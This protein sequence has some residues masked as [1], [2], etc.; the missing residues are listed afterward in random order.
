MAKETVKQDL[1]VIDENLRHKCKVGL[2]AFQNISGG[3]NY[4]NRLLELPEPKDILLIT[5]LFQS[6]II[7]YA[8]PFTNNKGAK[9]Y[10]FKNL[11]KVIGFD[12]ELHDHIIDIRQTLIAHDDFTIVEP[13]LI[14]S[15]IQIRPN[16]NE[17]YKILYSTQM[18]NHC[19][20]LPS[21]IEFIIK[22][23]E[24]FYKTAEIVYKQLENDV[25][26][27]QQFI[28]INKGVIKEREQLYSTESL[29]IKSNQT[30]NVDV[31]DPFQIGIGNSLAPNFEIA[32]NG[33]IYET[34]QYKRE[35]E[36]PEKIISIAGTEYF[37]DKIKDPSS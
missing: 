2:K 10:P 30:F 14:T 32:P 16:D 18:Q 7:R 1:S 23:Q 31:P 6:A 28:D 4:L 12:K 21:D 17:L 8:K 29:S 37:L 34:S 24:H 35:Y 3:L 19:L 9:E 26:A 20:M 13:A 33:Y 22:I 15:Y 11:S 27:H 25:F 36:L 5:S